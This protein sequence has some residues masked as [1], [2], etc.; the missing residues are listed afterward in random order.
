MKAAELRE[1]LEGVVREFLA[2]VTDEKFSTVGPDTYY[3]NTVISTGQG[4][5]IK[6]MSGPHPKDVGE[7]CQQANS[8]YG[9]SATFTQKA[10]CLPPPPP[11]G[12]PQK[13]AYL[14]YTIKVASAPS[15]AY[16]MNAAEVREELER[17]VRE[18]LANVTDETLAEVAPGTYYGNGFIQ[19]GTACAWKSGPDSSQSQACQQ[20][21][22]FYASN[23]TATV[24][25]ACANPGSPPWFMIVVS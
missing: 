19:Y 7:A 8:Y 4:S 25:G 14:N 17:D 11:P 23:A 5:A 6:F 2:K 9:A 24:Q 21:N 15:R 12:K 13:K 16:P 22:T 3:G 10:S 1:K 18:L 20:T